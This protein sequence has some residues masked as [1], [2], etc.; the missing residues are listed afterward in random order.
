M[1]VSSPIPDAH[2]ATPE[3]YVESPTDFA[4]ST[5]P[6]QIPASSRLGVLT[7]SVSPF[8]TS[9]SFGAHTKPEPSS[10]SSQDDVEASELAR[11]R[12]GQVAPSGS[13]D[14]HGPQDWD[15]RR[16]RPGLSDVTDLEEFGPPSDGVPRLS[17]DSVSVYSDEDDD[18]PDL[19]VSP[20]PSDLTRSHSSSD[21]LSR[22]RNGGGDPRFSSMTQGS[23]LSSMTQ[24]SRLSS[25]TQG[26]RLSTASRLSNLTT[27]SRISSLA[28]SFSS[29]AEEEEA[30]ISHAFVFNGGAQSAM[31]RSN[32]PQPLNIS[33]GGGFDIRSGASSAS[34][35][36]FSPTQLS[37]GEEAP[38]GLSP[39]VDEAANA[40]DEAAHSFFVRQG[41]QDSF[42]VLRATQNLNS[43]SSEIG[44]N[45]SEAR[46]DQ[47]CD[48]RR[49][50]YE[51][52]EEKEEDEDQ[53]RRRAW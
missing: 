53:P 37:P 1:R 4:L 28:P 11:E 49:D 42:G 5:S 17:R 47:S 45:E 2:V 18:V 34:T 7:P 14:D 20:S 26:S 36:F 39:D 6:R 32:R 44:W 13:S 46:F 52:E 25:M 22:R 9:A 33:V 50:D 12:Y 41:S 43:T 15:D 3:G 31:S 48:G 30:V 38:A 19:H 40:L 29:S 16:P 8:P 51:E 23:R 10:P 24:G 27:T 35:A 21:S